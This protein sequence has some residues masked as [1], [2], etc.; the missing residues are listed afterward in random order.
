MDE[1]QAKRNGIKTTKTANKTEYLAKN[2]APSATMQQLREGS[3]P[4]LSCKTTRK[5][6]LDPI[7]L[8]SLKTH[9]GVKKKLVSRQFHIC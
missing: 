7:H 4:T 6:H 5:S 1:R 3:H 9:W 8:L 2:V